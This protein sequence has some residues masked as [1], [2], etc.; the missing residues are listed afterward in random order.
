MKE[1]ISNFD[2]SYLWRILYDNVF[3]QKI[4]GNDYVQLL[5]DY[6]YDED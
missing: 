1:H 2:R 3:M 6:I 4:K 5:I